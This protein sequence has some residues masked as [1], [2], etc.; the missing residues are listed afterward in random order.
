MTT[1]TEPLTIEELN[2]RFSYDPE[3]GAITRNIRMGGYPA[4]SVAGCAQRDYY[5]VS[6]DHRRISAHRMAWA[7]HY[8]AWPK[9]TIDH[10]N[11]DRF[12]NRIANLRLATV[13][14]NVRN[15]PRCANNTSGYKGVR[16]DKRTGRYIV[17]IT[18]N[19]VTHQLGT[20][21]TADNA[22]AAYEDAAKRFH[23]E[24]T[25]TSD[26]DTLSREDELLACL[27]W[28]L[29]LA[30]R[31]VDDQRL[32]R[33][34]YGHSDITG[35][36][37]NGVTW[38]GIHQSEVD[39][40]ERARAAVRGCITARALPLPKAGETETAFEIWEDD[41][42]VASASTE[43]EGRHYFAVYSQDGPVK[44]VRAETVRQ[45]IATPST[46]GRKGE[47]QADG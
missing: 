39:D 15:R 10:I 5:Y 14:E 35:T 13:A 31:A 41:L 1:T 34:R 32:E 17:A 30:E 42:M 46:E 25:N 7:L 12:D 28:A 44:L 36:Y 3:T 4:G 38:A 20:F 23:G 11:N 37:K 26:R 33:I 18:V 2:R 16:F 27:R 19:K 47:D 43:A 40:I 21:A 22:V 6:V 24:F 9:L 45:V 29:P 8:G